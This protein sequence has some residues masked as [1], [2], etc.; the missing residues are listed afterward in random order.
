MGAGN[1]TAPG[2]T[3]MATDTTLTENQLVAALE[4]VSADPCPASADQA[5]V[6]D[7]TPQAQIQAQAQTKDEKKTQALVQIND[8]EQALNE[9]EG[10]GPAQEPPVAAPADPPPAGQAADAAAASAKPAALKFLVGKKAKPGE[11]EHP[12]TIPA[13]P[14]PAIQTTDPKPQPQPTASAA[15][16][17]TVSAPSSL[18]RASRQAYRGI[19]SGLEVIS[20]PIARLGPGWLRGVGVFGVTTIGISLASMAALPV[21]FPHEDAVT[22]LAQRR[23]AIEHP[24]P[25]APAES[26]GHGESSAAKKS[27]KKDAH[28]K[29]AGHAGGAKSS[30][31]GDGAKASSHGESAKSDGKGESKKSGE[32]GESKKPGAHGESAKSAEKKAKAGQHG[33]SAKPK[34]NAA[35][36]GHGH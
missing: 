35:E 27:A 9:I 4:S 3:A 31:H 29:S 7:S 16:E 34:K 15:A 13:T 10:K 2:D 11:G 24:P 12:P 26:G 18:Y 8:I 25:P 5:T 21:L 32:H 23:A 36:G 30:G 28:G 19:E 6:A 14:A 17:T 20:R 33:G 22:F 1:A